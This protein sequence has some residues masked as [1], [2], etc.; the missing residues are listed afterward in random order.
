[1]NCNRVGYDFKW[2]THDSLVANRANVITFLFLFRNLRLIDYGS[3]KYEYLAYITR[4]YKATKNRM[5]IR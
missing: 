1:M 5:H 3:E 4:Y 2:P